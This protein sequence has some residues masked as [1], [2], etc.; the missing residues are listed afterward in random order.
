M[1]N[2]QLNNIIHGIQFLIIL[3]KKDPNFSSYTS[4]QVEK[5]TGLAA[6]VCTILVSLSQEESNKVSPSETFVN[7]E[8]IDMDWKMYIAIRSKNKKKIHEAF[9][10]MKLQ[11]LKEDGNIAIEHLDLS[12]Q[13]FEVSDHQW[14]FYEIFLLIAFLYRNLLLLLLL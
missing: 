11:L 12:M 2:N 10:R 4:Q 8:I 6:E 7:G 13:E 14:Y 1:T 9:V 3:I 5:M